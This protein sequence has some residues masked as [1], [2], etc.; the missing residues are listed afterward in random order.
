MH[1]RKHKFEHVDREETE[2]FEL[3]EKGSDEKRN[4]GSHF[5]SLF[6]RLRSHLHSTDSVE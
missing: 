6:N 2:C 1:E 4:F 5:V 3:F